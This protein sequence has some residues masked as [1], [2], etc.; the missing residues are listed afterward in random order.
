MQAQELYGLV[1][2]KMPAREYIHVEELE[3]DESVLS[4]Q[5][6]VNPAVNENEI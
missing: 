6:S 4:S 5:R 2:D 1:R 3:L